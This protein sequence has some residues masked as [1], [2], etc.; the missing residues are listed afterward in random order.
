MLIFGIGRKLP[1]VAMGAA[2]LLW[3]RPRSGVFVLHQQWTSSNV[4]VGTIHVRGRGMNAS[5]SVKDGA[6]TIVA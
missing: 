1:A 2:S 4:G 5:G 6:F 3:L